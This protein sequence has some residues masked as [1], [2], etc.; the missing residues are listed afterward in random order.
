MRSYIPVPKKYTT[1]QLRRFWSK[2]DKT[3]KNDCWLWTGSK[4]KGGY[5]QVCIDGR[6]YYVTRVMLALHGLYS[7]KL[8]VCHSCNIRNC[9]NIKHLR[10]DTHISNQA[11][12]VKAGTRAQGSQIVQSKL[13]E[14]D[15]PIIRKLTE[16]MTQ[17]EV[18]KIFGIGK[19]AVGA[20][21]TG[22]RW[23][24]IKT[25]ASQKQVTKYLK[26]YTRS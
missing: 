7:N 3:G 22:I 18:A 11:D 5:G 25:V 16:T 13:I 20:I 14:T 26:Q 15:I 8:E 24:H 6:K 23:K 12:Q 10:F 1:E 9:C 2:I 21:I 4:T 17:T 19:K